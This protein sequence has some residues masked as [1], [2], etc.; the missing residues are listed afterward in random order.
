MDW[1]DKL[2]LNHIM[3]SPSAIILCAAVLRY[4]DLGI[5]AL[6]KYFSAAQI[7]AEIDAAAVALKARVDQDAAQTPKP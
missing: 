6:L 3:H 1:I 5:L 4:L 2:V 7:D